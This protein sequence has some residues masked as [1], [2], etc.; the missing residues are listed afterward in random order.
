M[1]E[2]KNRI[3]AVKKIL[4]KKDSLLICI[5]TGV[6]LLVMVWPVQH[7]QESSINNAQS[8][9]DK[10]SGVN[11]KPEYMGDGKRSYDGWREDE[12]AAALEKRLEAILSEMEG[13]GRVKVMLT[14][15]SS[16]EKII[17]KDSPTARSSIQESDSTGGS[18]ST[19]EVDSEE[20]TVYIRKETGEQVP[21][22]V[23]EVSPLVEGVSVVAEG[24][25]NAV[26]QK[27][28][29][30]VI[31]ALFGIEVHKIKVVKMK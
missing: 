11:P 14:L 9:K 5:L 28:I 13:V 23:K 12:Q 22:V 21:Y 2:E 20:T 8:G 26:V 3:T 7:N 17:E 19:Q 29:T 16:G 30:E 1:K 27:N 31:Q 25:S 6:L 4:L 15:A 18:R 24:G 10:S